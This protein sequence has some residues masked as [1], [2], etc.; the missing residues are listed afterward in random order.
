MDKPVKPEQPE[1]TA[2]LAAGLY[3]MREE[4]L[5]PMWD[6]RILPNGLASVTPEEWR[7]L[8]K[9]RRGPGGD[10]TKA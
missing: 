7:S 10:T 3:P 9:I 6:G 8:K 2:K 1:Q 5:I 4:Q